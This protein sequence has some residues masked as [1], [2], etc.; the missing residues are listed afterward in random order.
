MESVINFNHANSMKDHYQ[1]RRFYNKIMDIKM[2][3]FERRN[4]G[5]VPYSYIIINLINTCIWV[6]YIWLPSTRLHAVSVYHIDKVNKVIKYIYIYTHFI[7]L[8]PYQ[9]EFYDLYLHSY[10]SK[11]VTF[12]RCLYYKKNCWSSLNRF[13]IHFKMCWFCPNIYALNKTRWCLFSS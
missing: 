1:L 8:F 7:I 6:A 13:E 4:N 10:F 2:I 11:C 3:C 12:C 5:R 9:N